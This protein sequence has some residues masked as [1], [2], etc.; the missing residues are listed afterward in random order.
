[1]KKSLSERFRHAFAFEKQEDFT[2]DERD[3]ELIEVVCKAVVE[4]GM[5]TPATLFLESTRPLNYIGSQA[6]V[7]FEPVVRAV[8]RHPE[9]WER[10]SR[11]LEHRGAIEYLCRRIEA[12]DDERRKPASPSKTDSADPSAEEAE[13]TARSTP[14]DE[15]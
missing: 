13:A 7:F 8:L 11:I 6:M 9:A 4:R 14:P 12:L 1:M 2:P 10:F 15:Q 3:Q 5:A